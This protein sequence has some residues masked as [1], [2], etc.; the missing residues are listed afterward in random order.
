[1]RGGE[2]P[3]SYPAT[4]TITIE[5]RTVA[6]DTLKQLKGEMEDLLKAVAKNVADFSYDF[7]V[8]FSRSAFEISAVH[9]LV[10]MLNE[11]VK[12]VTG[13]EGRMRTEAAWTDCALLSDAGIPVVMYGPHGEGL[14][15]KEEWV[16]LKSVE[17]VA[18]TLTAVSRAFCGQDPV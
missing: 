12:H 5:R 3:A 18:S 17:R 14:H 7:K 13:A 15:A 10:V 4:C 8:T 2:E 9:P 6:G 11:Q 1:V 16:D